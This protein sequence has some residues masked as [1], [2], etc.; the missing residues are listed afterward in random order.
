MYRVSSNMP[1]DDF[2]YRMLRQDHRV[3]EMD[4]KISSSNRITN[5]RDDPIAAAHSTRLKSN[6]TRMERFNQNIDHTRGRF[7]E[8]EGYMDES[9]S[10]I[11]RLR[12][13]TV[14]GANGTYTEDDREMM[15]V[16]VNELLNQLVTVANTTSVDGRGSVWRYR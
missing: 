8:V 4:R 16:E 12:E 5:L 7:R 9:L 2:R 13:L 6:I 3:S 10:I 14:Q 11:H 15:A 1:N